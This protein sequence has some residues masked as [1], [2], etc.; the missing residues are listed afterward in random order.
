MDDRRWDNN[1]SISF[2]SFCLW[3]QKLMVRWYGNFSIILPFILFTAIFNYTFQSSYHQYPLCMGRCF[4]GLVSFLKIF[5]NLFSFATNITHLQHYY[6]VDKWWPNIYSIWLTS[7][8]RFFYI[9]LFFLYLWLRIKKGN[10]AKKWPQGAIR[11]SQNRISIAL[12]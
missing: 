7:I 12:K 11:L 6:A 3:C 10:E 9:S 2:H 8:E 5:F 4:C 1:K